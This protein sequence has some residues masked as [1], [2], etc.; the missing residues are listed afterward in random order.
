MFGKDKLFSTKKVQLS[1]GCNVSYIDEG[2]GTTTLLFVHGLATYSYSW[3]M[4]IAGL[5]NDFRCIAIDL[6]G[7]GYS[8]GGDY[9]Y[10]INFYSGCVY[11]FIQKLGLRNVVLV[12]HSM[13]AQIILNLAANQPNAATKLVLCAPAGFE[14]F[15]GMERTLYKTGISFFD[16]FSTDEFNLRQTIHSSF[17][18][19][20]S[21]AENMV[22]ELVD[23]MR[24]QPTSQY[25]KMIEGCINGMME[26]PVY[27]KLSTITIPTLVIFGN[28]DALIPNRLIHPTTT[29]SI[30]ESGTKEMQNAT[31][32]MIP[33]CGHFVQLEKPEKVNELIREFAP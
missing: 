32:K 2:T 16:F 6:P 15:N 18:N 9:P 25:R 4:N 11:D 28:S 13:G 31:L 14:Q 1:N 33:N 5:K 21:K 17:F 23:I 22:N 7:N 10:G 12:G 19:Y 20:P 30:A 8:D 27:D 3:A 26:E 24:H 29:R